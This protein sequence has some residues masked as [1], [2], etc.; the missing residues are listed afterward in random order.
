[1]YA[2]TKAFAYTYG[3]GINEQFGEEIDMLTAV[4]KDDKEDEN[5]GI[6]EDTAQ[7]VRSSPLLT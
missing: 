5:H 1:M 3:L 4:S 2:A 7:V 6:E